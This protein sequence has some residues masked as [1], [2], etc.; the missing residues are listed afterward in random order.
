[1]RQA[2]GRIVRAIGA[3]AMVLAMWAGPSVAADPTAPPSP[4][5]FT[6]DQDHQ[7]MMGQLGI[8]KLRP[9]P[10]GDE[11]APDHANYDEA[12]A[13]PFTTLPDPLTLKDGRKVVTAEQ[14]WKLRRPEIV[15]DFEQEVYGFVPKAA[16]TVTWTV[17]A[18]DREFYGFMPV[19][20]RKLVGHL[21]N[22]AYPAIDVNI[23][24]IVSRS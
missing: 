18:T 13:T 1:M 20:A 7:N 24:M 10:S 17:E 19:I 8:E 21:D 9:G 22:S 12:K 5:T 23:R 11:K 4:V 2:S 15:E 6:T 16:P 14:W 3:S